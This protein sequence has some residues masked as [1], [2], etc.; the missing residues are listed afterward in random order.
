[1]RELIKQK[2]FLHRFVNN[3]VCHPCI[4]QCTFSLTIQLLDG[5]YSVANLQALQFEIPGMVHGLT[6]QFKVIMHT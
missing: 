2:V 5:P 1:M 3:Y 4:N 6:Y